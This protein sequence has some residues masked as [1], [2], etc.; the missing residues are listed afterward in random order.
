MKVGEEGGGEWRAGCSIKG[1]LNLHS[2]TMALLQPKTAKT[3][4]VLQKSQIETKISSSANQTLLSCCI[5][6]C[7]PFL[8]LTARSNLLA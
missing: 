1:G 2:G 3:G 4:E 6:F 7:A 8:D 5:V